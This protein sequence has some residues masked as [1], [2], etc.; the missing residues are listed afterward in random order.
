[1]SI[2]PCGT[3]D[4]HQPACL[5]HFPDF[6]FAWSLMTYKNQLLGETHHQHGPKLIQDKDE[7]SSRNR[8]D[9]QQLGSLLARQTCT[10]KSRGAVQH[11]GND[12]FK[13][14]LQTSRCPKSSALSGNKI[15]INFI[16]IPKQL[17]TL[18]SSMRPCWTHLHSSHLPHNLLFFKQKCPDY[19]AV[20]KETGS[21]WNIPSKSRAVKCI[22]FEG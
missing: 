2:F 7:R 13:L 16:Q 8:K 5:P 22:Q 1:M 20:D 15:L 17:S 21:S 9:N 3:Q 12:Y 19:P 4:V 18:E 14:W 10:K 11:C 6:D